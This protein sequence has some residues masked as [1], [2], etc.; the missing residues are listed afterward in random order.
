MKIQNNLPI[1]GSQTRKSAQSRSDGVFHALFEAEVADVQHTGEQHTNDD[2][3][4]SEHAWRAL[5]E[6]ISLLDQAMQCLE[7]GDAPTPQLMDSI[8]QLRTTLHQQMASGSDALTLTQAEILLAVEIE[9]I[10][11]LQS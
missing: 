8:E 5:E 11:S 3:R 9:R 6:S 10:H 1:R 2:G 4:R 7:S